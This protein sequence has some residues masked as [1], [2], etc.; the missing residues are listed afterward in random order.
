MISGKGFWIEPEIKKIESTKVIASIN[1][2]SPLE[3]TFNKLF[4]E[5]I[6]AKLKT[7]N[8]LAIFD[9]TTLPNAISD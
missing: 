3:T 7:N 2:I 8:I 6:S 9:P 4:F 1:N 5:T